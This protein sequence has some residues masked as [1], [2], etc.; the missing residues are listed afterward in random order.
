[1]PVSKEYLEFVHETLAPLGAIS[2]KR[3]FG[4]AGIH[5]HGLM[6]AMV[7]NDELYFKVD[8]ASR[9]RYLAR[10]CPPFSYATKNGRRALKSYFKVPDELLDDEEELVAWARTA[11]DVALAADRAKR[12]GKR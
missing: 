2:V 12:K 3:L 5:Y 11:A 6:F 10:D 4:G 8:E 9:K 1:M 7:M